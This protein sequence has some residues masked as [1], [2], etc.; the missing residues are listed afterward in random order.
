LGL[1]SAA[2]ANDTGRPRETD[3]GFPFEDNPSTLPPI[4]PPSAPVGTTGM[5][6]AGAKPPPMTVGDAFCFGAV[7]A[8]GVVSDACLQCTCALNPGATAAC[9]FDC[10]RLLV[11]VAHSCA[12]TDTNCIVQRCNP[13]GDVSMLAATGNLARAVPIESCASKCFPDLV[14]E[15]AGIDN[16]F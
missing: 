13:S 7:D 4:T 14:S 15:E 3:D 8:R 9:N 1:L 12:K 10:W 5:S 11:C 16:D 2:C 6:S